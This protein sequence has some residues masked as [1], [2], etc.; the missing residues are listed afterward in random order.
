[1]LPL[2]TEVVEVVRGLLT[3]VL[4]EY[5]RPHRR[6]LR[7]VVNVVLQGPVGL[8]PVQHGRSGGRVCDEGRAG[9]V[10]PA[11]KRPNDGGLP[12]SPKAGKLCGVV[13]DVSLE[14]VPSLSV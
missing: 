2:A 7:S 13:P 3:I 9:S 11:A 8:L 4:P 12:E 5:A 6:C 14:V 1:M 10:G